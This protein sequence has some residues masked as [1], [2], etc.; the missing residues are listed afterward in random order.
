[1]LIRNPAVVW[2]DE[3]RQREEILE[4]VERGE[5]VGERGWVVLV[6]GGAMHELN[7]TAGEIWCLFDGVRAVE[8]VAAELAR[9]Y[10]APAEEILADV[11]EFAADWLRRGWLQRKGAR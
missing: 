6:D 10:D 3:P 9:L 2:R 7:L 1:V 8:D 4:A 5:D 11:E